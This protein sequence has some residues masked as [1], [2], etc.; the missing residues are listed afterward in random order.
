MGMCVRAQACGGVADGRRAWE[1]VV[2]VRGFR[3]V[4]GGV[5]MGVQAGRRID[6][7]RYKNRRVVSFALYPFF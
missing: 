6:G 4:E 3:L 2:R 1:G 5:G 7:M